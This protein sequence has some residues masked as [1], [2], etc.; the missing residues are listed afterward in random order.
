MNITPGPGVC[1]SLSH[2]QKTGP[3]ILALTV[4]IHLRSQAT[5]KNKRHC[6]LHL[7]S[8]PLCQERGC[9]SEACVLPFGVRRWPR[10]GIVGAVWKIRVD[11]KLSI[12]AL[13]EVSDSICQVLSPP[14]SPRPQHKGFTNLPPPHLAPPPSCI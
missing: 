2:F 3:L 4:H 8:V 13:P 14:F 12:T 9:G 1:P 10:R 6:R 11:P 5:G 7:H